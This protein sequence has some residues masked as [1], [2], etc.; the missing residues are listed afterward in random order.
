MNNQNNNNKVWLVTVAMGY[1]HQRT[2]YPL[3]GIAFKGKAINANN[4]DGIPD[5]D[6]KIWLNS[7]DFYEFISRLKRIPLIGN[8]IFSIYDKFQQIPSFY[9]ERDLSK[10]TIALKK[11]FSIIKIV[12]NAST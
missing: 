2:A 4:Y 10:P 7:K 8:V 3:K 5:K 6:R 11:I 12:R 9:P 1:G